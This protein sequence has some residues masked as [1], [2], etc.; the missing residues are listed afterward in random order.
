M[1][2][3]PVVADHVVFKWRPGRSIKH[4]NR[5][6]NGHRHRLL[7]LK[8]QVVCSDP[9]LQICSPTRIV[10][11]IFLVQYPPILPYDTLSGNMLK[12]YT[13]LLLR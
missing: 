8:N 1:G 10:N 7:S 13:Q 2:R 9:Q 12:A 4:C 11:P 3:D 6:Y 5:L